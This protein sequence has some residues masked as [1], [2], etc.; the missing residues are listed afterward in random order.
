[1]PGTGCGYQRAR[2]FMLTSGYTVLLHLA[3]KPTLME[4]ISS[5]SNSKTDRNQ[6]NLW[7]HPPDC[8]SSVLFPCKDCV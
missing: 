2:F 6:N 8:G 3:R 5:K 1:M 4:N 7:T